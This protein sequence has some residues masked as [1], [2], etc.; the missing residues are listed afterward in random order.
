MRVAGADACPAGW[1][2]VELVSGRFSRAVVAGGFAGL[3]EALAGPQAVGVDI[4][5]GLPARGVRPA[6]RAARDFV[7]PRRSSVF[8][9]PTRAQLKRR[10]AAGLGVSWQAH[11]MGRRIFEVERLADAT[12][13]EVHPEVSFR[14][15]A[16]A[17]LAYAK[18]TW[19]G[20]QERLR[21]LAGAGVRLPARLVVAGEVAADDLID[22]AVVA[23]SAARVAAGEAHSL[24]AG[25]APGSRAV[26]W[27]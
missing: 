15:L 12:V 23:W 3:L 24:P 19:N 25:A 18:R 14:Q 10:W 9:T 22:A 2:A 4:P 13:H 1:V 6:D 26:I 8:L 5:I 11:G 16:G 27:Y 20:Q 7:G 17:P 21:L